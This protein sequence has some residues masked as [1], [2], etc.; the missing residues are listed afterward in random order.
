[1]FPP[2]MISMNTLERRFGWLSFPGFLRYY[3]LLFALVYVLQGFRPEMM[4]LMAFDPERILKGEVW[5]LITFLFSTTQ[6]TGFGAMSAIFLFFTVM[7]NF[8]ISDSLETAWGVFKTSLFFYTGMFFLIVASWIFPGT[9][10]IAGYL[11]VSSAFLAFA[12]LF[13]RVELMLFFIIP[14]QI[15]FFGWL[16]AGYLILLAVSSAPMAVM[17]ISGIA[18][19]LL[20]AGIPAIRGTASV[21]E[22]SK[23]RRRFNAA[24]DDRGNAF[25]TCASC[26]RTDLSDPRLEFRV[27]KDGREYC[28]DHLRDN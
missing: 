19:Y 16:L 22:A 24:L 17:V 26:D 10:G 3:I 2:G 23:R 14:V 6:A 21:I 7:I 15:R 25:H 1:M 28:V 11:F 13:P 20:F 8:M 18:N 4:S 12:T 9:S 27:G 5:R